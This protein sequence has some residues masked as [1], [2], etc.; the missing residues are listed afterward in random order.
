MTYIL[1]QVK[2]A[3]NLDL[4][5]SLRINAPQVLKPHEKLTKPEVPPFF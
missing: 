4:T 3:E 1:V 5:S 2:N